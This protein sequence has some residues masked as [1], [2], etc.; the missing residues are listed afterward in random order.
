MADTYVTP[1]ASLQEP[2]SESGGTAQLTALGQ[3]Y[4]SMHSSAAAAQ[5]EGLEGLEA[6]ALSPAELLEA[7]VPDYFA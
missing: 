4:F 5:A 2:L 6:A 1:P 7:P 3:A